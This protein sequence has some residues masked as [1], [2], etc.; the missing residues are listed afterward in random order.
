MFTSVAR[1]TTLAE[2]A[3]HQLAQL[4]LDLRLRPGDRL[5]SQEE[6][7][8]KMGVSRTVIREAVLLLVARG[9]LES[10]KGSGLFVRSPGSEM[11]KGPVGLLVRSNVIT[12][13]A[14]TEAREILEPK[15]AELAALHRQSGDIEML[16][17]TV[18][19][20]DSR[21]LTPAEYAGLDLA[22]HQGLA[23]ASGNP[24]LHAMALSIND[25][26]INLYQ[27]VTN[28]YGTSWICERARLHHARILHGVRA[29]DAAEARKAMKEHMVFSREVLQMLEGKDA[30]GDVPMME[31]EA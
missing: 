26:L 27:R 31:Q 24:L 11:L 3:Q 13:E 7:G 28:L 12:R 10:R 6:L 29:G 4:I 22:F 2:Q 14:I 21:R 25:V 16:E 18:R 8:K 20:M 15:I 30:A 19:Q 23:G 17:A 1:S 5:P 9:L